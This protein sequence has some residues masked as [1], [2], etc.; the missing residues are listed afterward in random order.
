MSKLGFA[1]SAA[2]VKFSSREDWKTSL[3]RYFPHATCSSR[4]QPF[5]KGE[6]ENQ[7]NFAS[8]K[9]GRFFKEETTPSLDVSQFIEDPE[10]T[11]RRLS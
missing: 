9:L 5:P 1:M 8:P 2:D 7:F 4:T 3:S 6:G 10:S 11:K